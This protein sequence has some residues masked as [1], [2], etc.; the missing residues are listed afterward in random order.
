MDQIALIKLSALD[1]HR[2]YLARDFSPVEVVEALSRQI[3]RVEP[4]LNAVTTRTLDRAVE[5]AREAELRYGARQAIGPLDGVPFM[6][7]DL[8][9]TAGIR[10]TYG[11]ALFSDHVPGSDAASVARARAAGAILMGKS[12]THEFGW[13]ITTDNPHFGPTR[14]PWALEYV[15]GGSSGGSSVALASFQVPLALGTDTGGSIRI[16]SAFCG[17]VGL[18]PTRGLV[19]TKGAFPLARS[20]DHVG[21]MARTPADILPLLRAIAQPNLQQVGAPETWQKSLDHHAGSGPDGLRIGICPS[22]YAVP[23]AKDVQAVFD[24]AIQTLETLGI[25]IVEVAC[26]GAE[27]LYPTFATILLAE[28]RF[29][30]ERLGLFPARQVDYGHDVLARLQ[31]AG[32]VSLKD[33]LAANE[34]RDD[35]LGEFVALFRHVDLLL[36]PVSAGSPIKRGAEWVI[37]LGQQIEFRELVMTSTVLQNLTG[38]PACTVR[39]GFDAG[40]L[41]V[42][43]QFTGRLWEEMTILRVAQAFFEATA[44]IQQTWPQFP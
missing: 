24:A 14:N 41:P 32:T 40:G 6:V 27:D 28:A 25:K 23:L 44:D 8:L 39:A 20:L 18:K 38:S 43:V 4:T 30:H 2:G 29:S 26:S 13:G 5:E 42:G 3:E 36:S 12:A 21:P 15:P 10:T 33:Y 37:H 7:K 31:K 35:L 22:L 1:L 19:S 11:S 16:P 17:V 9:D 34:R